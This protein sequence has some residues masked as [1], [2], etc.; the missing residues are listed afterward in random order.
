MNVCD[1]VAALRSFSCLMS[2]LLKKK[3]FI[4]DCEIADAGLPWAFSTL[5]RNLTSAGCNI[6]SNRIKGQMVRAHRAYS[7]RIKGQMVGRR[8]LAYRNT[9]AL[10]MLVPD[11]SAVTHIHWLEISSHDLPLEHTHSSARNICVCLIADAKA[12][13]QCERTMCIAESV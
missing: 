10:L 12:N 8:K 3:T 2:H 13:V 6:H 5:G 4:C 11:T 9:P 7:N 1:Y